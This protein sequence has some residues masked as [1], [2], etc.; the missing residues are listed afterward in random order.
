M[1]ATL[2]C[3]TSLG[4][5]TLAIA[6]LLYTALCGSLY[7]FQRDILYKPATTYTA[8]NP[9]SLPTMQEVTFTTE[10]NMTLHSWFAPSTTEKPTILFLHGN[11]GGL[12][13]R[14]ATYQAI[15]EAG[16]GLLALEYRGYSGNAGKPTEEGLYQDAR[17]ALSYLNEHGVPS[18]HV[19]VMGHSLGT[20]VAV[21]MATEYPLT[22]IVLI[23]PYTSM[24]A[25][26]NDQYW[27][28]P[29]GLLLKDRFDS[30]SKATQVDDPVL[31]FHGEHDALIPVTQGRAL[32]AA[33]TAAPRKQIIID[34]SA[35]HNDLPMTTILPTLETFLA[36]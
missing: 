8:P 24:I 21:Q 7:V 13:E 30:L 6:L 5:R 25:M 35:T 16:Y 1:H 32:N 26:A 34:P 10:D 15:M 36:P 31:I 28:V 2:F 19:V 23:A 17:A 12:Q 14:T 29:A 9:A 18:K 22:A 11:A 4:R 33:L 20:G 3:K 27:Y